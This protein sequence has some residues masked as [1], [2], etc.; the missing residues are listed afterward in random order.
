VAFR[1]R[2]TI[3]IARPPEDVFAFLVDLDNLSR[4]QPSVRDVRWSGDLHEGDEFEE[5]R[6][7]LGRRARSRLEV[8]ALEAAREFSIR[9]VEGPIPLTVRHLL[10]PAG[11]GT[12][13]TL[14]AEGEAGGLMRLAAPIAE[15]AAARQAGQDLER[16][17]RLI[18]ESQ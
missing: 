8:T 13:L 4:W 12:R 16:L 17:K 15:R 9:V 2:R 3:E 5:T 11:Q 6:E 18:E 1:Y 14:E 10:E 7:M